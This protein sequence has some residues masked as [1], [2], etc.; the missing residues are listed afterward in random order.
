[1]TQTTIN[2]RKALTVVAAVP[3]AVA[4][5][6]IPALA[7]VGEDAGL[8]QLWAEYLAAI[9]AHDKAHAI[10][11]EA[12]MPYDIE[13]DL[14][15]VNYQHRGGFGELHGLLWKKH[16]VDPSCN[17][18]NREGRKVRRI[19]KAIRKAKADSLFGVGV[20][21]SVSEDRS[22]VDQVDLAEAI[23]DARQAIADLTGVDF[24]AATGSL[25]DEEAM[26]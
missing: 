26:A 20:K 15:K 16:G 6:A 4:L 12:R 5:A 19:V 11:R 1:M 22:A 9:A 7:S 23:D 24:I 13:F 18:W 25:M 8:R 10:F 17:A 14:L 3:A 2:R 21:L